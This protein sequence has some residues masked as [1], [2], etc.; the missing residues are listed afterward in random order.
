MEKKQEKIF[1]FELDHCPFCGMDGTLRLIQALNK[2]TILAC[3]YC[4]KW[5]YKLKIIETYFNPENMKPSWFK[6]N[7]PGR[8]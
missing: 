7:Y 6:K 4:N 5:V 1:A 8:F 3:L 2:P